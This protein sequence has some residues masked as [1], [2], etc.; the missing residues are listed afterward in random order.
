[1]EVK[2][3][4]ETDQLFGSDLNERD[5][6]ELAQQTS[7]AKQLGCFESSMILGAYDSDYEPNGP[8]DGMKKPSA[9]IGLQNL[10][11][12]IPLE[13]KFELSHRKEPYNIATIGVK[14]DLKTDNYVNTLLLPP[15]P[16]TFILAFTPYFCGNESSAHPL[17][18]NPTSSRK[19]IPNHFKF[20][21]KFHLAK[22]D[23]D[24]YR[25]IPIRNDRGNEITAENP[26][27]SAFFIPQLT[28]QCSSNKNNVSLH[29]NAES[30]NHND[31]AFE[32]S[33][34]I[35]PFIRTFDTR[36][37]QFKIQN[38]NLNSN[39]L[40]G[41]DKTKNEPEMKRKKILLLLILPSVIDKD[42]QSEDSDDETDQFPLTENINTKDIE[43]QRHN[44]ENEGRTTR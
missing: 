41:D 28:Q 29:F 34:P 19:S 25:M 13:L 17:N 35:L 4:K 26:G 42:P 38:I 24:N 14:S 22:I 18:T 31:P 44:E 37:M 27:V 8:F 23:F 15:A 5:D 6:A 10:K 33:L 21:P 3:S 2:L 39:I 43:K 16:T 7:K 32:I 40:D 30:L 1:M 20:L 12:L 36:L 11:V 9:L